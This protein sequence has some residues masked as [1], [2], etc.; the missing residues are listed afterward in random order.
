MD[1]SLAEEL[2]IHQPDFISEALFVFS[3]MV[4]L[5]WVLPSWVQRPGSFPEDR[6]SNQMRRHLKGHF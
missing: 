5:I 1:M 2:V 4:L 3:G 6:E